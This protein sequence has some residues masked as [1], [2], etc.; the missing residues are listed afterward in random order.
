MDKMNCLTVRR[1]ISTHVKDNSDAFLEH[2]SECS[3]CRS[4]Y[5]KQ[6]RFNNSLKQAL[7]IEVPEGLAERVLVELNLNEKKTNQKNLKWLAMAAS[8]LLV[9]VMFS[10]APF[11][12]PPAL[13]DAI[14]EHVK[15][16]VAALREKSDISLQQLNQLLKPHGVKADRNIG[17]ATS[18]GICVIKG[19]RGAHVVFQGNNKPVTVIILPEQLKADDEDAINDPL[20]K[21]YLVSTKHGTLAVISEDEESLQEF[22]IRM[23]DNL[24][25][26]I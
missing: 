17:K 7:E 22:K 25:I 21:G 13:A 18:A 23:R 20:Y 15:Y 5:E 11:H 26:Y 3:S 24:M 8:I 1:I 4:F 9:V 19:K 2:L 14:V 12:T 6:L 10:T 16:D